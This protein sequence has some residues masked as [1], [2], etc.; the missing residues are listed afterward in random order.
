MTV[1]FVA[2]KGAT[3]PELDMHTRGQD[4]RLQHNCVSFQREIG[5]SL[6]KLASESDLQGVFKITYKKLVISDG[7]SK[8]IRNILYDK[9]IELE[10]K[11]HII[12]FI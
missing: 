8:S 7:G 4:P 9:S 5:G 3:F 1:R 2:Y 12:D 10:I 6:K 11:T